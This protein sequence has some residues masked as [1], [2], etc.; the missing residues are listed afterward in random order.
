MRERSS[1]SVKIY[2]PKFSK[3]ELIERLKRCAKDIS[4]KIPLRLV[5]LFGSYAS[6]R[7][8]AASDID[9]LIVYEGSRR[10]DA[11]NICWDLIQ[12]PN[13]EL[14]IYSEDE[15]AKLKKSKSPLPK[16]AEEKGIII[17]RK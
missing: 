5:V 8:T 9:V 1:N 17:W 14:H 6:G 12:L 10:E 3:N 11:Y 7:Q 16:E 15:Y 2:Y 13:L 4:K